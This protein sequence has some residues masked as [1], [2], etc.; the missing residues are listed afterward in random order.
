MSQNSLFIFDRN[1]RIS[2]HALLH[3]ACTRSEAIAFL[4]C[5]PKRLFTSAWLKNSAMGSLRWQFLI[6]SLEDLRRQ[7]AA[8]GHQLL[9]QSDSVHQVL[10][11]LIPE[12]RIDTLYLGE[13]AG[14]DEQQEHQLIQ[15]LTPGI[16]MHTQ[17]TLP[18]FKPA[19]LPFKSNDLP[20]HFTPFRRQIESQ[21][22][23]QPLAT[24]TC[25]PKPI[26]VKLQDNARLFSLTNKRLKTLFKGGEVAAQA[27]LNHYFSTQ[28][29]GN[30]KQVR[31]RLYGW[32][33][34]TKFSPWLALGCVSPNQ[35]MD[36]LRRYEIAHGSNE[37]TYWI[38]FELLWRDFFYYNARKQGVRLFHSTKTT[39]TSPTMDKSIFNKWCR[40]ETQSRL[41]NACMQQLNHSGYMSNRGRQI[42]AS[43]LIHDLRQP[44]QSG[45]AYFER[46]L[47]DYDV[48]SNWG[49]WQYI[50][51][52]GADPR[53]G[54]HFNVEKQQKIHD[55][56]HVF[57]D[58]WSH[59]KQAPPPISWHHILSRTDL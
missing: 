53:G 12:C 45:A 3:H 1:L 54:R 11:K 36:Q 23:A 48:A 18:L 33:N 39:R 14:Y 43:Y 10:Q 20:A 15:K 2:D 59:K 29:P 55:P 44:W 38:Y 5:L 31:N 26:T 30:Y 41:V 49:N 13:T 52:V 22:F 40:G 51:G 7:L 57:I 47:I 34:S 58:D 50:A 6:E 27:H 4:Y 24:P 37:S 25:W 16:T 17:S 21:S 28:L 8:Y 19:D 9:I 35:I 32:K 46:H 42:A 56:D